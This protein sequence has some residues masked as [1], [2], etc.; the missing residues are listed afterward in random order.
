MDKVA[1]LPE[2]ERRELFYETSAHIGLPL[3]AI[4]EKDFWVCWTLKQIYSLPRPYSNVIS[5]SDIAEKALQ[6]SKLMDAV[7]KF[8]QIFFRRGWIDYENAN[9]GTFRLL[10]PDN[11]LNA[12]KSD[13][14]SMVS[15]MFFGPAPKF[16]ELVVELKSLE[17]RINAIT[18]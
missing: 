6:N 12:L 2:S 3:P 8:D 17:K 10:P 4:A 9:P 1:I 18:E 13:Y 7:R 5:R 16:D 11:K 15:E 14:D